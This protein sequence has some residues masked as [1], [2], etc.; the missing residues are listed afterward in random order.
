MSAPSEGEAGTGS[1]W[2][3]SPASPAIVCFFAYSLAIAVGWFVIGIYDHPSPLWSLLAGDVAA[4]GVIFIIGT[5]V[6]NSSVYD[7]YWS[8]A[9][10]VLM[11]Y[12]MFHA[13]GNEALTERELIVFALVIIYGVRLTL[14]CFRRWQD[15]TYEDFRYQNFREQFG[16]FYPVIDFF[17]IQLFPTLMVFGGCMAVFAVTHVDAPLG[18]IDLLAFVVTLGAVVIET[19]ADEQLQAF[20]VSAHGE[21]EVCKRGLWAWSQHPNYFGELGF[22]WGLWIFAMALG[23]EWWWTIAGPVA[24]T[25]LFVAVSLPMMLKRK[26][27]RRPS[28]DEQV[29]GI[30]VLIPWPPRKSS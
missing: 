5:I 13:T 6:R 22:W 8:T 19:V 28:Y 4:T 3:S 27:M 15:M 18:L 10:A 14:N 30:S 7:P 12:W 17:G 9:P 16:V 2:K 25:A 21:D 11:L 29:K 26:R 20:K 1:T 24:M 23:S